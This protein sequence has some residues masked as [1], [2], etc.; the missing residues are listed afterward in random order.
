MLAKEIELEKVKAEHSSRGLSILLHGVISLPGA[1]PCDKCLLAMKH[2]HIRCQVMR[3]DFHCYS[4]NS[5]VSPFHV[6]F[7]QL[8]LLIEC[9]N[10]VFILSTHI[11]INMKVSIQFTNE[12]RYEI[13]DNVVCATSKA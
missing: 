13:S 12:P 6:E 3:N 2:F 4:N 8:V 10:L 1:T 7:K 9:W 5:S 11:K